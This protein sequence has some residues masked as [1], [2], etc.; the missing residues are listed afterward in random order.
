MLEVY[1]TVCK[2]HK[3]LTDY[4]EKKILMCEITPFLKSY[5]IVQ[6]HEMQHNT[7]NFIGGD[8]T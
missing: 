4:T 7:N 5:H 6:T 3:C 8:F 1:K 2:N